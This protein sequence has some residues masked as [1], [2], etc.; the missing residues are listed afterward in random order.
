MNQW[1][2][3]HLM[4]KWAKGFEYSSQKRKYTWKDAM[5]YPQEQCRLLQPGT[6]LICPLAVLAQGYEKSGGFLVFPSGHS[7]FLAWMLSSTESENDRLLMQ[8]PTLR[9]VAHISPFA[10]DL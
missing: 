2:C 3:Y 7:E 6:V 10:V 5:F 8:L 4:E 9:M 1:E